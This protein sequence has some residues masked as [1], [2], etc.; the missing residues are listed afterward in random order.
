MGT[1]FPCYLDI[2]TK[3]SLS[4][5]GSDFLRAY[6]AHHF[7][8]RE[9]SKFV[10]KTLAFFDYISYLCTKKREA[11]KNVMDVASFLDK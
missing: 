10:M 8:A 4:S 9:I 6:F 2:Q 5:T 3:E 11:T 7:C 1:S